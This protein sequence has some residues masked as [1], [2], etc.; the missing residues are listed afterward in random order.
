MPRI[1][2]SAPDFTMECCHD[3]QF[4]E[5]SLAD[6]RGGWLVLFFYP[7]DFTFV[8][9]TEIRG[10]DDEWN[11][12]RELNTA[13]LGV[14]VDSVHSH[15]AWMERDLQGLHFPLASDITKRVSRDYGV[16]VEEKGISLRGT[17]IIDDCGVLRYAL[18]HDNNIGRN[19]GEV[20]R[21]LQ[22]LQ[23]GGLCPVN[24]KPGEKMLS[25]G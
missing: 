11:R 7:L 18:V 6:Y 3:G 22:A 4:K 8:C 17:F 23:T 25:P 24:W 5:V 2:E 20:L 19:T 21:A 10:F 13:V 16:L 9:P 15:K 14:S 1:G 12:F